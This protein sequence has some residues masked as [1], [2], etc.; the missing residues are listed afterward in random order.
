MRSHDGS[1][2]HAASD[3]NTFLGCAHAAA[4]NLQRLRDPSS[5]PEPV[6]ADE[7]MAL[8]Q[9]AGHAHEADYLESLKKTF[10]V[11]EICEVLDRFPIAP[12]PRSTRCVVAL[13]SSTR[14]LFS[15]RPGTASRTSCAAS[16]SPL[17]LARG[18]TRWSTPS[19]RAR[20]NPATCCSLACTP[21]S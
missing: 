16:N 21:I 8:V 2:L 14:P 5:L 11:H 1:I 18:P 15:R 10:E 13:L 4:L 12:M 20:R 17:D 6:E 3:L 9:D 19:S 7:T